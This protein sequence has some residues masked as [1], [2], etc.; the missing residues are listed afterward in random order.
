VQR[1]ELIWEKVFQETGL[2]LI[3]MNLSSRNDDFHNARNRYLLK[4]FC[5]NQNTKKV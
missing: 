4:M 1:K 3:A 2:T 5:I